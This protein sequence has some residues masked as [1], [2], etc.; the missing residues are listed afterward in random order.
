MFGIFRGVE[1]PDIHTGDG[2]LDVELWTRAR[3]FRSSVLSAAG[4]RSVN[5][6][7]LSLPYG[8]GVTP[9]TNGTIK[10][11]SIIFGCTGAIV[12]PP[13]NP[14]LVGGVAYVK[15][16]GEIEVIVGPGEG[17]TA[18]CGNEIWVSANPGIFTTVNNGNPPCGLILD[19]RKY[20]NAN[21]GL[22]KIQGRFPALPI[23]GPG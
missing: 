1:K 18:R 16:E 6:D 3:K 4:T 7:A 17:A 15:C 13:N 2:R 10:R 5:S 20:S 23:A 19:N 11:S 12:N 14:A 21:G 8:T 22:V 9:D